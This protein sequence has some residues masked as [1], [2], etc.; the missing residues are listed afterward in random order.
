MNDIAERQNDPRIQSSLRARENVL[1]G[2]KLA[3]GW[4][5]AIGLIIPIISFFVPAD[6]EAK[7]MI[8]LIGFLVAA[9]DVVVFD[10]WM[11]ERTKLAARLIEKFD[12]DV[13]SLAPNEFVTGKEVAFEIISTEAT[14]KM[15]TSDEA[16]LPDWYSNN[17]A[18]LPVH[19]ARLV[20]QKSNLFWDMTQ[21]KHYRHLLLGC[22]SVLLLIAVVLSLAAGFK[23][24]ELVLALTPVVPFALWAVRESNRHQEA[25][26]ASE[27]LEGE[28]AGLLQ[29]ALGGASVQ[30][31]ESRSREL[32]DAIFNRRVSSPLVFDIIYNRLRP[33]LERQMQDSAADWARRL[34][35]VGTTG[36]HSANTTTGNETGGAANAELMR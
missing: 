21:R 18:A 28:V 34:G 14:R 6:S 25:I 15:K 30:K 13:L 19:L 7:A 4:F 33:T 3:Q 5:V 22:V 8:A 12:C 9:F 36:P 24:S 31:L 2:A 16:R 29:S 26:T 17:T 32:Q 10:R 27:R 20:C 35:R 11:K 23:V 1:S